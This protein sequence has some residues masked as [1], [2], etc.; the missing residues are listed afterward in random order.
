MKSITVTIYVLLLLSCNNNNQKVPNSVQ[1]KK[2]LTNESKSQINIDEKIKKNDKLFLDFW[3]YMS[4][5]EYLQ[6]RNKLKSEN[7]ISRT[8]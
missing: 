8:N 5:D 7:I 1:K 6:V 2:V 4:Q 3:L